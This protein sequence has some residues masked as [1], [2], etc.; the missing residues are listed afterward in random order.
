MANELEP[1]KTPTTEPRRYTWFE[2]WTMVLTQPR[3]ETFR[4]V[5]DDPSARPQRAYLWIFFTA[6]VSVF[7]TMNILLSDPT[8]ASQLFLVEPGLRESF[9][10]SLFVTIL[11]ATPIAA[12][13]VVVVLILFSMGVQFVADQIGPR[14]QTAGR[15]QYIAYALAAFTAP[16]A[17]LNTLLLLLPILSIFGLVLLFYQIWLAILASRAV[18]GF[19]AGKAATT[20][21][22]PG[23]VLIL[24][25]FLFVGQ[26]FG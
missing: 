18:Y 15:S 3:V 21:L 12:V 13:I 14:S 6:A 2:I 11:C 25:Q 4:A 1:Q 7:V 20:I 24:F 9:Q 8:I 5:L 22:V 19:D 23:V 17:V 16:I 26:M 10:S